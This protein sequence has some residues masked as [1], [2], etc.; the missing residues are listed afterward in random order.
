MAT[1]T[2]WLEASARTQPLVMMLEDLQWA[3]PSTLEL[4]E[5][6]VDR[7]ATAPMMLIY[8]ARPEF[9]ASWPVQAHHSRA[10]AGA[11]EPRADARTG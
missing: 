2:N 5:L 4:Q 9:Q 7:A 3:D 6:L 8:T 11:A 1:L 10:R